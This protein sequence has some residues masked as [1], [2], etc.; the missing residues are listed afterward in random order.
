MVGKGEWNSVGFFVRFS[1]FK[2]YGRL[3]QNM[4]E[5]LRLSVVQQNRPISDRFHHK[6]SL[7]ASQIGFVS[8]FSHF[9]S[10]VITE[11]KDSFRE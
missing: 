11:L 2:S 8:N 9:T 4:Y 7:P 6:Y 1:Y 10:L 3:Y 5:H